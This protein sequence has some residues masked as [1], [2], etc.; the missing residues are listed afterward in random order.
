[1][2]N[3]LMAYVDLVDA[4]VAY[5]G[6]NPNTQ[7]IQSANRAAMQAYLS[8]VKVHDWSFYKRNFSIPTSAPYITGTVQYL[9]TGGATCERQLTLTG[10]TWPT[11]AAYGYVQ[12]NQ[13]AFQVSKYFSGSVIQLSDVNNPGSDIT[14]DTPFTLYRDMYPLPN[15]YTESFNAVVQPRLTPLMYVPIAQWTYGRDYYQNASVPYAFTVT[16]DLV[17]PQRQACRLY[18]APDSSGYSILFTYK[19]DVTAPQYRKVSKGDVTVTNGSAFVTGNGTQWEAAM[20]G[21]VLRVARSGDT[22]LP[23]GIEGESPAF[24]EGIVDSVQSATGLTLQ[25]NATV[26]CNRAMYVISSLLDVD[27]YAMRE[28]LFQEARRQYRTMARMAAIVG[29]AQDYMKALNQ[30]RDADSR[31]AGWK[32]ASPYQPVRTI[33]DIASLPY[34][35]N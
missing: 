11:W 33:Y 3:P 21:T 19:S 18:P 2:P 15:D 1:M 27:P 12:V 7:N 6:A 4:V 17:V 32:G 8:L 16:K 24:F 31:Y 29:E 22:T 5:S 26:S 35:S 14:V 9:Q 10:G 30:A 34:S 28:Y 25:A 23:T 13:M 20:S